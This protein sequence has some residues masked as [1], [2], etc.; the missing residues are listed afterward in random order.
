[1]S[2]QQPLS[3]GE[4]DKLARRLIDV[5]L[6]NTSRVDRPTAVFTAGQPGSG[7][8]QIVRYMAVDF[9]TKGGAIAIDAD[10]IRPNIPYMRERIDKGDLNIP[11]AA[12]QDAGTIAAKMMRL[13]A[14]ERRN[15]IY[16]GTLTNVRYAR[17]NTEYLQSTN[18]RVEVHSMAVDPD[19]S[20]ARTYNRREAE[21]LVSPTGFGR[22][23]GDR[24]HDDAVAGLVTTIKALQ[25][26]G[27]VDA[28]SLYD[29]TGLKTGT[30]EYRDGKWVPDR[31]IAAQL[32]E[33]HDRP[34]QGSRHEAANTWTK[35]ATLMAD[36]NADPVEL[37][38]VE[39][40]RDA[41]RSLADA[42]SAAPRPDQQEL[43]KLRETER[44]KDRMT[45]LSPN[46]AHLIL[47]DILPI[48]RLEAAQALRVAAKAGAPA[49]ELDRA[50]SDLAYV[51]HPK[52]PAYQAAL[53]KELGTRDLQ[54]VINGKQTP[55][56]RTRELGAAIGSELKKYQPAQ[57]EKAM[58]AIEQKPIAPTKAAAPIVN[59]TEPAK[60]QECDRSR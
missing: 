51:N 45:I 38:K 12:F 25:D 36:R 27:K 41:S 19:L 59:K 54:A 46:K 8:S 3:D 37:R 42:G 1:M 32:K 23:V 21:I 18:Y 7:K 4:R 13:A 53:V 20:Q 29:R 2:E 24:F 48:A 17:E 55:L 22:G 60:A 39:A 28:I 49:S 14:E 43:A 33:I 50:R 26:E 5:Q 10:A 56:D 35:A 57:I 6:S 47:D 11:D 9:G 31:D 58:V 44:P 52:G 30:V 40:M 15:I 34:D 16:D